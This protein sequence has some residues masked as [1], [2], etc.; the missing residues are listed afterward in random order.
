MA[1]PTTVQR[2]VILTHE[3]ADFDALAS[4]LAA[5]RLYPQAI[6][7]LPRQMNRNLEAF[8]SEYGEVLPF[9]AAGGSASADGLTAPLLS[10]RRPSSPF[11][12]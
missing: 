3:H 4:M 9:V 6:P 12:G 7:V 11:G 2:T 10:T 5:A 8:L 1:I